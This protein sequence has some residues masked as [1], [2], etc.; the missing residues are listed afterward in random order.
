[1]PDVTGHQLQTVVQGCARDLKIGVVEP[2]PCSF[3]IGSQFAEELRHGGVVGQDRDGRQYP[4]FDIGQVPFP[5]CRPERPVIQLADGY[6]ADELVLAWNATEPIHECRQ[7]L[8]PEHFGD[9]VGIEQV[10]QVRP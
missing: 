6:R 10:G 4:F 7:R 8:R 5:S 3:E 9:G 2:R 1:M